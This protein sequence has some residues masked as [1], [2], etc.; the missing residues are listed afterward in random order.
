LPKGESELTLAGS[1]RLK[2]SRNYKAE[3][4]QLKRR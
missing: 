3:V 2:V 4:A 1:V